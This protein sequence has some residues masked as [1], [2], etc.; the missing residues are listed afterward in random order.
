MATLR[1]LRPA[2]ARTGDKA[3]KAAF[4]AALKGVKGVSKVSAGSY[5]G[6]AS[7]A[8]ARDNAP[9][10]PNPDRAR[11]ADNSGK[12]DPNAKLQAFY[13]DARKGAK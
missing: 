13:D 2:I 7:A 4:D 9:R 8:R 1:A 12:A 10:N 6:F 11:A 5:G 3:V